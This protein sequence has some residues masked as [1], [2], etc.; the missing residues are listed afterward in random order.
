MVI[1]NHF[2]VFAN[3]GLLIYWHLPTK[4]EHSKP[5]TYCTLKVVGALYCTGQNA[6]GTA[7]WCPFCH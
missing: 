5:P 3:F 1:S 7:G 2:I 6:G 4:I